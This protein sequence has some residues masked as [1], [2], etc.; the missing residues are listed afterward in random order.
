MKPTRL[1]AIAAA[2]AMTALPLP[3]SAQDTAGD[4]GSA[5]YEQFRNPSMSARPRV[6]WHWMNGNITKDGIRKDLQ[7]MRR[8]GV[9]GF[10]NFDANLETPQVVEN[11]LVYMTPEWKDAFR[12]ALDEADSLGME[13][14]IASSPGWSET[15]GP[16]VK[17]EDAM[18]KLVWRQ[19]E[20]EGQLAAPV[21]RRGNRRGN[22]APVP[23]EQVIPLPDGFD[24]SGVFQDDM[25]AHWNTDVQM[26]FY[27][28]IAVLA[29]KIPDSDVDFGRLQ[30]II[31]ASSQV[32][33]AGKAIDGPIPFGLLNSDSMRGG[34]VLHAGADHSCWLQ[35]E[36]EQPQTVRSVVVSE[37]K[38]GDKNSAARELQCSDD[39]VHFRT[40]A[41]LAYQSTI[42]KTWSFPAETARFFRIVFSDGQKLAECDFSVYQFMLSS[43]TRIQ[44]AG[45]KA[46]LGFYRLLHLE[47]TPSDSAVA[48]LDDVVELT[49]RFVDGKLTWAVPEGR[50]R[51]FRFGYSLTGK[52]NHPASAEATGF[53]VDKLDPRA[54]RNYLENYLATY[55]DASGGRLGPGGISHLLTDSYE[56]GPQTWTGNMAAEFK[57]RK[58]YDVMRWLPAITGMALNSTD[59]TERFLFDWRRCIGEMLVEYHYD[60]QNEV[61]AQYGMKRYTESHEN[62]RAL[63]SD[64]MDCKRKA[65]IPMSA[66]WMTYNQGTFFTP[67]FEADL[68]ESSS[69]AHIYGQNLTAAESFTA[70]GFRD[71]AWVYSPAVLKPTADAAMAAGLNRFIVHTSPHQPVD[72]KFPGLGLGKYGQWFDRHQTWAE[73]AWAWTDYL[74]RSCEMLQQGQCVSDIAWYYGEDNNLTGIFLRDYPAVPAGYNYD[75]FSKSVLVDDSR[76]ENG[77]IVVPS[78]LRYRVLVIDP[79]VPF[80]SMPVLRRMKELADAG[81]VIVGPAPAKLAGMDGSE[82]AFAATVASVW[83]SGRRNVLPFSDLAMALSSAG[84]DPDFRTVSYSG[85][86]DWQK[87]DANTGRG[88]KYVHRHTAEGEIYWVSNQTRSACSFDASFRASGLKPELWHA[89]DGSREAVSYA[90]A[91]GRTTVPMRLEP[92]ESVFVT[93]LTPAESPSLTLPERQEEQL[94]VLDGDWTVAFQENRGAPSGNFQLPLGSLTQNEEYGIR[95]FSGIASYC[96]NFRLSRRTL[97][98]A[99]RLMLDLGEV[100]DLAEVWVNGRK[101]AVLWHAPFRLDITDAL[102]A[103]ENTIEVKVVNTWH[104]RIVGDVRLQDASERVTYYPLD[105]LKPD[106]PLLPAGLMGPVKIMNVL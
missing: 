28:D 33:A 54:V 27:R 50:W 72:D 98:S 82:E 102:R 62:Y 86:G 95:Y 66:Y 57:A 80:M 6:W 42:Q 61:L 94:L 13:V 44:D 46:G 15:G 51:I 41:T 77:A 11:R 48:R 97:R 5:I 32:T 29:V 88:L 71:G 99:G 38:Q 17:A 76:L 81:V 93:F 78:G 39:G 85:V 100:K 8:N 14:T 87:V 16:W 90:I 96:R 73:Q 36:F 64:G 23:V 10:H 60:I 84:I 20:V 74:S 59:E 4:A 47:S 69:V 25:S 49:D 26:P 12:F 1:C 31:S 101:L 75:Y 37:L 56:A 103:G 2:A 18:K 3:A 24:C 40:V 65:E 106:E 63:L 89:E 21:A 19:L 45:D 9:V 53:E 22:A 70:D 92:F 83:E 34:V 55:K 105:L 79:G 35:Y 104:N 43:V 52:T 58:G 67:R 30:P 91:D 7:W 68:R